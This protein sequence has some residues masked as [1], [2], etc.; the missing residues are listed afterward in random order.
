MIIELERLNKRKKNEPRNVS[1]IYFLC[2][3]VM[4]K[5]SILEE[6]LKKMNSR[7]LNFFGI[8]LAI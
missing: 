7:S 8:V 2:P 1:D 3:T 4:S 6:A 5:C